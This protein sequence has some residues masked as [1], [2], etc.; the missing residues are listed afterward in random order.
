[1]ATILIL[2]A[3]TEG[4]TARISERVAQTLRAQGHAAQTCPVEVAERYI[5]AAKYDAVII[6]ASIHYGRHPRSL[7][8][9]VRDHRAILDERSSAFFSVSLSAGGPGA[10]PEAA[11]RYLDKFLRQ[12]HW[13]PRQTARFAGALQF[14]KY[15]AFKRLLML[16]FVGLAGG[17]TDTSRDY[18]YTDWEAVDQFAKTFAARLGREGATAA[19]RN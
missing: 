7:R 1:M 2:Y 4:Q 6:G 19:P 3:T 13:Y 5:S 15:G 9:L 8:A 12:V 18:E 16:I 10:K 14:S 17:D 11:K